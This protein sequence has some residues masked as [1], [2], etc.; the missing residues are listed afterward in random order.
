MRNQVNNA[1]YNNDW[2]KAQIGASRVKQVLW[3]FINVIFFINPLNPVS[4][5][6]ILLL[7]SF[8]ASIGKD[9]LI[10]QA[11]NIKYPWKLVVGDN[12]WIGE[13]VWI[14][15]LAKIRIGNNVC[16]SQGAML[17]TGNHDYSLPTFNL[18]ARPI[19]LADGVWI[20]AKSVVCPGVHCESHAV[21]AVNSVATHALA[22]YGIYQGNPAVRVRQRHIRA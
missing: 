1:S 14:D 17:L 9:V 21:L 22:A 18:T 2:Y 8:G 6:K 10:K 7:K 15:N 19:T 16:L 13:N 4:S 3:Y 5:L 12:T 11:V 20:G